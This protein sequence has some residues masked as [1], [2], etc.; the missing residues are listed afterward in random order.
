MDVIDNG[1]GFDSEHAER[2]F[3]MFQRLHAHGEYE[4]NGIGLAI[5]ARIAERHHGR[6]EAHGTPGEGSTFSLTIGAVPE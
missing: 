4:G 6:I 2:I 1:I 5:C 3:M